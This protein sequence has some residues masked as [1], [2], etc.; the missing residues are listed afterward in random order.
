MDPLVRGDLFITV[1]QVNLPGCI[2][3]NEEI[4]IHSGYLVRIKTCKSQLNEV[5]GKILGGG[6]IRFRSSRKVGLT[7][8]KMPAFKK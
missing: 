2:P 3:S 1:N 8:A 7:Y 6:D 5:S 4:V